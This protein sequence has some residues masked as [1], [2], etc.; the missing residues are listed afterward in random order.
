MQGGELCWRDA[1]DG[2]VRSLFVVVA[3]SADDF[4]PGVVDLGEANII[5]RI[6]YG[7]LRAGNQAAG[8]ADAAV[9]PAQR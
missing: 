6:A 4:L 2:A 3:A 5:A 1:P 9:P 7:Y 8:D